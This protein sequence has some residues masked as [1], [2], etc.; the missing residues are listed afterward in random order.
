[1][2]AALSRAGLS[3]KSRLPAEIRQC[4]QHCC[5]GNDGLAVQ[6]NAIKSDIPATKKVF[7]GPLLEVLIVFQMSMATWFRTT[8]A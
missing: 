8:I 6:P 4:A 1:M 5:A 2:R 7:R 3:W